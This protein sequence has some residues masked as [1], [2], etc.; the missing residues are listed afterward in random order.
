MAWCC[1]AGN[2]LLVATAAAEEG[3]NI[4]NCQFVVRFNST[5]TGAAS[6]SSRL[7][8]SLW[9]AGLGAGLCCALLR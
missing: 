4:P 5:Q 7:L 8:W 1:I 6:G 3:V 2:L 9:G